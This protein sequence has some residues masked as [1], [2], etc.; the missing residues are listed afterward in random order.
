MKVN[1]IFSW[2]FQ[3]VKFKNHVATISN[4]K[5]LKRFDKFY[6]S[7]SIKIL[8]LNISFRGQFSK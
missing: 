8:Y 6:H 2:K 4:Y 3:R 7:Y 1:D 5:K